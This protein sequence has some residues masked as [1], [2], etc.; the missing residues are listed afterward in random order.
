M[1]LVDRGQRFLITSHGHKPEP[2]RFAGEF[3]LDEFDTGHRA[4]L[5]KGVFQIRF[6]GVEREITDV[7]FRAHGNLLGSSCDSRGRA[8]P[9]VSDAGFIA[10]SLRE[11]DEHPQDRLTLDWFIAF[12]PLP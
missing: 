4:S 5:P 11:R 1:K 7:E 3:V 6:C 12:F 2:A 10:N 9:G 8:E